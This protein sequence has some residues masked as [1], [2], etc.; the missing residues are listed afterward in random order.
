MKIS[1]LLELREQDYIANMKHILVGYPLAQYSKIVN[2]S[3][4]KRKEIG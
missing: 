2:N 3:I 1:A 4:T